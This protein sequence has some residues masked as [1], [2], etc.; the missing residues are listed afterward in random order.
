[1]IS[2]EDWGSNT[3]AEIIRRATNPSGFVST[4]R[5]RQYNMIERQSSQEPVLVLKTSKTLN[6]GSAKTDYELFH[7]RMTMH[8]MSDQELAEFKAKATGSRNQITTQTADSQ[9][10]SVRTQY[11]RQID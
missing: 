3:K 10:E 8:T 2:E 5:S 11:D 4:A 9:S 6:H 1:M 7:R